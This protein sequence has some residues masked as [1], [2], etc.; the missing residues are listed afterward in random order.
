MLE[1]LEGGRGIEKNVLSRDWKE[2]YV[3]GQSWAVVV[4]INKL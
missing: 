2:K 4:A 3:Q 1:S